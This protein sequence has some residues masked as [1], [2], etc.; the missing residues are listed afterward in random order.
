MSYFGGNFVYDLQATFL[1]GFLWKFV[2]M[3]F[4][5]KSTHLHFWWC[6]PQ[7]SVCYRVKGHILVHILVCAL[8][9]AFRDIFFF[10]FCMVYILLKIYTTLAFGDAAPSVLSYTGVKVIFWLVSGVR[11]AGHISWFYL[12]V[13]L[14]VWAFTIVRGIH[15]RCAAADISR[16]M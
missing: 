9:A 11:S 6:C 5:V 4:I 2:Q 15:L 16:W 3:C 13:I 14:Y 12:G 7:C 8:T 10:K 1:G